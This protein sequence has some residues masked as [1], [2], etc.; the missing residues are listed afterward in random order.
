MKL[1]LD[2]ARRETV[3]G[4]GVV[5]AG[6]NEKICAVKA[7]T[8]T[9]TGKGKGRLGDKFD[10]LFDGTYTTPVTLETIDYCDTEYMDCSEWTNA[11]GTAQVYL[12]PAD[13]SLG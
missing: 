1:F 7:K 2:K 5:T 13:E 9:V 4:A 10:V 11:T 3:V 6:T 12:I 8:S